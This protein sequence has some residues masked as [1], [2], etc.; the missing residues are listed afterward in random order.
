MTTLMK[1][2]MKKP[3]TLPFANSYDNVFSQLLD[4]ISEAESVFPDN[5]GAAPATSIPDRT[6]AAETNL[7]NDASSLH[8]DESS[9]HNNTASLHNDAASLHNEEASLHNDTTNLHDDVLKSPGDVLDPFPTYSNPL[10]QVL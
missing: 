8:N 7:H 5:I 1:A 4:T 10:S 6:E 9:L 3:R 2:L